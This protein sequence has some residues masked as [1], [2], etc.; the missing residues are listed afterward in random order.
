MRKLCLVARRAE[1]ETVAVLRALLYQ[2]QEGSIAG[3]AL[4]FM[5]PG[6]DEELV[7]T[8]PYWERPAEA[9]RAALRASMVLTQMEQPARRKP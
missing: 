4:S 1:T 7:C 5:R 9:V 3:V 8:G 2:A 6:G